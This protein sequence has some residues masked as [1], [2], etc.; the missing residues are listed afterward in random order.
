MTNAEYLQAIEA[1]LKHVRGHAKGYGEWEE[2]NRPEVMIEEG[3]GSRQGCL[4]GLG[5][6]HSARAIVA[7]FGDHDLDAF[8]HE[9]YVAG[10]LMYIREKEANELSYTREQDYFELLMSDYAPLV[11]FYASLRS[12]SERAW[13]S[14]NNPRD[15]LFR[16]YQMTLALSGEWELLARRAQE[17]LAEQPKGMARFMVDQ[18]FYLA[19]ARGDKAGMEAALAELTSPK[20]AKV[21]N[22]QMEFGFTHFFIG[23]HATMYAKIAWRAGYEVEVDTPYIPREWLPMK[24]LE[25][26]EDPYPF[27]QAYDTD[28]LSAK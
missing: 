5:S 17:Q 25:K 2:K 1:G 11:D 3:R 26:Y 10:K 12:F 8:K 19:L 9:C 22:N 23:T 7:W 24:P 21:R 18:R 16:H 28:H 15:H 13:K 6:L 20:M 4:Y 14:I 27:M